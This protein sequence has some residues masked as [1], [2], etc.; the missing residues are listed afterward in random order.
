MAPL[1]AAKTNLQRLA[2]MRL[3][4]IAGQLTA[5]LFA[6]GWLHAELHYSWLLTIVLLATLANALTFW[7][8]RR[9]WPVTDVEFFGHMLLDVAT[10]SVLLYLSGGA[11]NP[12]VSYYL[13]PLSISAAVLGWR[14]T[15]G[16]ALLCIGIYSLLLF[17]YQPL[18]ALFPQDYHAH[19]GGGINL[20]L[21]GMWCN[22]A[23]SAAL[24][25]FVVERMAAT[26]REQQQKLN[27]HREQ[28][29]HSEQVLAV[30]TLAAGTAHE[31]GTPLA[32]M[33]VLLDDM[34]S[35]EPTLQAD[36]ELLR[37]QVAS[38]R[39]TLKNLV[40]TADSHQRRQYPAQPVDQLLA[41]LL[42]RWQLLRP[43]ARCELLIESPPPAPKLCV[44][45]ALRQAITNLLDNGADTDSGPLQLRLSWD[46]A[47]ITLRIRDR[48]PGI[49]LAIAGQLGKAFVSNKK[50]KGLGL[51]LFLSS[52]TAERYGGEIRLY[53]H[54]DGGTEAE[55]R[56]P[57]NPERSP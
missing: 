35:D 3:I 43:A 27:R 13:V 9:P 4:M 50:G 10:L 47:E 57:I 36:I 44:D 32:T 19:G 16:L 21:F 45:D 28:A 48:G 46:H 49:D 14:Y 31:L 17:V 20:H 30:A 38:C 2:L 34:H 37:Q 25:S 7:R 15:A 39:A 40:D 6:Y 33:T 51:G 26:L 11:T 29:M 41:E 56:L 53:N 52:A 8:L 22:F 5:I 18:P 55:L 54:P 12:F 23:I 24:I 1:T 42:Q